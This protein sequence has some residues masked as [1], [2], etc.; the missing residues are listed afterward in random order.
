MTGFGGRRLAPPAL[1]HLIGCS[2][3]LDEVAFEAFS[4]ARQ[5][6]GRLGTIQTSSDWE[7]A[8]GSAAGV[9]G[10]GERSDFV[11]PRQTPN[12]FVIRT[13][14]AAAKLRLNL[15]NGTISRSRIYQASE[16]E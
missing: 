13:S 7:G 9:R 8:H 2:R 3:D 6:L 10:T 11:R 14:A 1:T 4:G 16:R 5:S 15:S 12:R